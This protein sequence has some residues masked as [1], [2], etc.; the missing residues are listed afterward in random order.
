MPHSYISGFERTYEES[1]TSIAE[2][3]LIFVCMCV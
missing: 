3:A 1:W 2:V